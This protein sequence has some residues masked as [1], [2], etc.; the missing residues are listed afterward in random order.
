M[1]KKTIYL[2]FYQLNRTRKTKSLY[3]QQ[4]QKKILNCVTLSKKTLN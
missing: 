1:Q 2:F 3:K 4:L